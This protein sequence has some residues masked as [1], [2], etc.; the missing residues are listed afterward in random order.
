[1]FF[2]DAVKTF[3]DAA[4]FEFAGESETECEAIVVNDV[5]S[6]AAR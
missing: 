3:D 1:L 2:D 6:S 5:L 4:G